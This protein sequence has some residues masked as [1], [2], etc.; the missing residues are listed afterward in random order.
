MSIDFVA[1]RT[2]TRLL[3]PKLAQRLTAAALTADKFTG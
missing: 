1:A 2:M 3:Y